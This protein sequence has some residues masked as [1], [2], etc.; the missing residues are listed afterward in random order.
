MRNLH[1]GRKFIFL[2]GLLAALTYAMPFFLVILNSLK[3]KYDIL[4]DPLS[5]PVKFEWKNFQMA[6][7]KMDYFQALGNSLLITVVSVLALIVISS[8]LAY[9]L[10]RKHTKFS[11]TIFMI[12]V[13]SMIVP[14]QSLMIPFIGFFGAKGPVSALGMLSTYGLVVFYM[15]FGVAMTTFL[16]H[17]FI[18]NI[19]FELDEA[20]K[21][22][23][24][25]DMTVFWRIIFPMLTPVTATVAIINSL[26]IWN[27]FLLPWIV[28]GSKGVD[29]H[30]LPLSTY[31]FYGMYSAN[32]GQAMAGLLLSI[33]PIIIFY[34]IMQ[35][36]II[37]GVSSGAVK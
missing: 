11:K 1:I 19:P 2:F 37:S 32:Y 23:G 26:W 5:I 3:T 28:V 36:Q 9:Y 18:S 15:G 20:A 10:A 34:F 22:D 8:M 31:I 12:L 35:R 16:Y 13:A 33:L 25:S 4:E 27:D 24:A 14:F 30:T 6:A 21:L 29:Y 17:G 7:R